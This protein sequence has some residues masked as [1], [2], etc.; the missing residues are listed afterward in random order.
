MNG[1]AWGVGM[2]DVNRAA[3]ADELR[4]RIDYWRANAIASFLA[5]DLDAFNE[6]TKML[7]AMID[8]KGADDET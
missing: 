8:S 1:R 7:A 2:L 3:D 6:A 5:G 4:Q